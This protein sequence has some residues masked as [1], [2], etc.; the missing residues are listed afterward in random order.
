[1]ISSRP[2][3]I[4]KVSKS[5]RYA[6]EKKNILY[7]LEIP[8]PTVTALQTTAAMMSRSVGPVFCK[9]SLETII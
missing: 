8:T 4:Q 7:A 6:D 2:R 1:M 5:R 3:Q 9:N